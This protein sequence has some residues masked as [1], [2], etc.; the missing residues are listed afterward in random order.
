MMCALIT[1]EGFRT[2]PCPSYPEIRLAV[3]PGAKVARAIEARSR[4]MPCISPPRA[5]SAWRRGA[6]ACAAVC[7]SR[8]PTTRSFRNTCVRACRFPW[9]LTYRWLRGFHGAARACMV[10]TRT[11]QA[12]LEHWGF[13]N[14]VRWQR[15]VDTAA[16]PAA[17]QGVPG[18]AASH[19]GL[20]R[21]TGDREEHRRVPENALGGSKLVVGDGPE[22]ARLEDELSGSR[23][24]RLSLWRA[25]WRRTWPRLM[26]LCFPAA[27]IPS[28]W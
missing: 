1:P 9:Q 8:P 5:R 16:V 22:R 14:V 10:S 21:A 7:I 13:R 23:V 19:R 17:G 12:E 3:F 20:C 28:G 15:G 4:P 26:C 2:I 27:P 18:S 11:M 24:C 6:I 25:N